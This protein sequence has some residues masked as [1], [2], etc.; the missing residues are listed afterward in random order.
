MLPLTL[1][2]S[3]NHFIQKIRF[4]YIHSVIGLRHWEKEKK[5]NFSL[6]LIDLMIHE[7]D[8]KRGNEL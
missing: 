8:I 4:K 2:R 7:I 6:G 3:G 1:N 5:F